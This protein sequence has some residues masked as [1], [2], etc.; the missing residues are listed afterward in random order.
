MSGVTL[1]PS[2]STGVFPE[3][4]VEDAIKRLA[5]IGWR[6]FELYSVHLA[7]MD[8]SP[9]PQRAFSALRR[10][11]EDLGVSICAIHDNTQG[12]KPERLVKWAQILGAK[13]IVVHPATE[14]SPEENLKL[15]QKWVK[16]AR[17]FEVGIAIENMHDMIPGI[18]GRRA[19]G[20]VPSELLWLVQNTDPNV[21]GVC[22]DTCHAHV[23]KLDQYKAIKALGRHLVHTHINDNI[24]TSEEQHLALFEGTIDWRAVMRALRE[25]DYKGAFNTEGGVSVTSLPLHIRPIKL[26]YLLELMKAIIESL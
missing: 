23:Q 6:N 12:V 1:E 22:W 14:K 4:R 17:G 18:E 25:I 11:C 20:A 24:S 7:N 16:A 8:K 2:I 19:F 15:V 3:L 21:V 5:E 10:L 26:R 9:D 13:W